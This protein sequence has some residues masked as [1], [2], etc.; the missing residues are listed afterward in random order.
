MLHRF[1]YHDKYKGKQY[2]KQR[3]TKEDGFSAD[4]YHT[5]S[6]TSGNTLLQTLF[7]VIRELHSGCKR[8]AGNLYYILPWFGWKLIKKFKC[9][10]SFCFHSRLRVKTVNLSKSLSAKIEKKVE[11]EK[12][13]IQATT[14]IFLSIN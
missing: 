9:S 14:S 7:V 1:H 10:V 3:G 5:R 11:R 2:T 6:G 12:Q 13:Y 4:R 8:K